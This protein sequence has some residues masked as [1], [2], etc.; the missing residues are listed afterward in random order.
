M[1]QVRCGFS[2]E[3]REYGINKMNNKQ[4]VVF[5]DRDGVIN[6]KAAEGDYVKSWEEFEFL[7]GVAGALALLA[8]NGCDLYIITNQRGIARGLM[9]EEDLCDIHSRMREELLR[10]GVAIAGIY[11]CPHD[12]NSC[13]CRKPKPG[14][15]FRA[16]REHGID[17]AS[18]F[19]VGDSQSDV[20]AGNAAGCKT[21]L[22]DTDANLIVTAKMILGSA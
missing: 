9:T 7:P 10:H 14:L 8:Q 4:I 21:I 6:K 22:V 12:K 1:R 3:E 16:S 5:L 20:E 13:D 19:F 17:L 18:A 15:F 2:G 11:Y